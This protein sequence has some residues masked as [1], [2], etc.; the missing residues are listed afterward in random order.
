MRKRSPGARAPLLKTQHVP[1][2]DLFLHARSFHIAA[3]RLAAAFSTEPE[4]FGDSAAFPVLFMYRHAVELHM[5]T[6]V[7]GAGS[8]FIA[9]K[10]DELS[11]Y[12]THSLSWLAQFVCQII[13]AVGW[14]DEFK[15]QGVENLADFKALIETINSVDPGSYTY[16][17]P[18]DPR[19]EASLREFGRRMDA[20]VELLSST[21]DA[22]AAEWDVRSEGVDI[23]GNDG[24]FTPTIQ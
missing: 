2:E 7:L 1:P 24:G 5:K 21:A 6:L 20:L 16:R 11:V 3:K 17:C 18:V 10:P 19:S 23:D 14:E 4:P 12:K 8:N 13:T 22:L 15:C 9:V